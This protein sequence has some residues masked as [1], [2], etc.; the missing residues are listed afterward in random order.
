MSFCRCTRKTEKI[1]QMVYSRGFT[2]QV[3]PPPPSFLPIPWHVHIY[4]LTYSRVWH[5]MFTR[6]NYRSL[7]QK[8]SIKET[9]FCKRETRFSQDLH[10]VVL[11]CD[12]TRLYTWHDFC[13]CVTWLM[14]MCDMTHSCVWH[15]SFIRLTWLIQL[16]DMAVPYM[17]H[18]SFI[19]VTWL[20]ELCDMA[21][22]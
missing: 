16:C 1:L 5:E 12:V 20:I 6:P 17:S 4:F 7:L 18:G 22:S 19:C 14:R 21:V 15:D 8:S 11:E 9:I 2:C 10:D 13:S 3:P